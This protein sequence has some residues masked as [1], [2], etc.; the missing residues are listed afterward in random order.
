MGVVLPASGEESWLQDEAWA[1]HWLQAAPLG[2]SEGP[3][4]QGSWTPSLAPWGFCTLLASEAPDPLG[5]LIAGVGYFIMGGPGP[6]DLLYSCGGGGGQRLTLRGEPLISF[7]KT[8]C[9][10]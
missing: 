8:F 4:V 7:S 1:P 5:S 9:L 3:S 10:A 6:P 2:W